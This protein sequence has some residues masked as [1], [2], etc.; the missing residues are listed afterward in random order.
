MTQLLMPQATAVWLVD[1]T[2]LTFKQ[3]A[4][5]CSMHPLEVQGIADGEVATNIVGQDPVLYGQIEAEEIKRCE[6][7]PAAVIQLRKRIDLPKV[8]QSK[9]RYTP[10]AKRQDKPAGILY[11]TKHFPQLADAQIVRLIGTTKQTITQ[12]REGTHRMSE[13]LEPKDPVMLGLCDAKLLNVEIEKANVKAAALE[14]NLASAR[15]ELAIRE[16]DNSAE[17][18]EM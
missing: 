3:I 18:N 14:K 8:K 5:L 6:A 16:N 15:A 7:D 11:L 10:V 4:D 1:N 12:V 2:T 13:E 17:P 9:A